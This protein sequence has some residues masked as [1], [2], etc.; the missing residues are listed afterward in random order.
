MANKGL[1]IETSLDLIYLLPS[2]FYL[3]HVIYYFY[4]SKISLSIYFYSISQP[5]LWHRRK[6][7]SVG[8]CVCFMI[9]CSEI[10]LSQD[11]VFQCSTGCNKNFFMSSTMVARPLVNASLISQFLK[12]SSVLIFWSMLWPCPLIKYPQNY[13]LYH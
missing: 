10:F 1:V 11:G 2:Y 12:T 3:I 7:F 5:S 4:L 6:H 9:T 13:R 8:I